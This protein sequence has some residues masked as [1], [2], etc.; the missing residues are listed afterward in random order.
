MNTILGVVCETGRAECNVVLRL[1][2][3]GT[4]PWLWLS[5]SPRGSGLRF[6]VVAWSGTQRR[7]VV[8][9]VSHSPTFPYLLS[10]HSGNRMSDGSSLSKLALIIVG[11]CHRRRHSCST[12]AVLGA[13]RL[14]WDLGGAR[15]PGRNFER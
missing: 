10:V 5:F 7:A 12:T 2:H 11:S 8:P 9:A 1:L 13:Q 4:V 6:H 14:L 15:C 3:T